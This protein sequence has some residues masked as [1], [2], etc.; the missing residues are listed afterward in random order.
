MGVYDAEKKYQQTFIKAW[1]SAGLDVL[2]CPAWV[3]PAPVVGSPG[4]PDAISY[5]VLYNVLGF[6]S[7]VVPEALVQPG[8]TTY[9]T[10]P[11][12]PEMQRERAQILLDG[13]EGMPVG[14]QVVGL[15]YR[16]ET[17]LRVMKLLETEEMR[18]RRPPSV[19]VAKL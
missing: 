2:V 8:E 11:E 18:T 17:V 5:S 7:G 13:S 15:P 14:I 16:D 19:A 1:R 9:E 4:V 12:Q 10:L 6:P 3:L